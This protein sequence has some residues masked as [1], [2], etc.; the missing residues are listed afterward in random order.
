MPGP[1]HQE[2]MTQNTAPR[3]LGG[4]NDIS[5][6]K[7]DVDVH[8]THPRAES[9]SETD[10]P[11]RSAIF[12]IEERYPPQNVVGARQPHTERTKNQDDSDEI[13]KTLFPHTDQIGSRVMNA[14]TGTG[15]QYNHYYSNTVIA[16]AGAR[17]HYGDRVSGGEGFD[18]SLSPYRVGT[19]QL[20]ASYNAIKNRSRF[21]SKKRPA[22]RSR[23]RHI[24]IQPAY[25]C[26]AA[27]STRPPR[28][29]QVIHGGYGPY[30]TTIFHPNRSPVHRSG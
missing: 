16:H 27:R 6:T 26:L 30:S 3:P 9:V 10:S 23:I 4:S 15:Q 14:N 20:T 25:R 29:L 19:E 13:Y 12:D 22:V 1:R 17:V 18:F 5:L 8:D 21:T 2:K 24:T 28:D 7:L 11:D